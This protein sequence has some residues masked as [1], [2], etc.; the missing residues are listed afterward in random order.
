[1]YLH[2][3]TKTSGQAGGSGTTKTGDEV[4]AGHGTTRP[5]K[6]WGDRMAGIRENPSSEEEDGEVGK[7]RKASEASSPRRGASEE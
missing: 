3:G 6:G 7:A 2:V 1:M 5:K 4:T